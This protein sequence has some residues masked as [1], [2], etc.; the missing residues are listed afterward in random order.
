MCSVMTEKKE[1]QGGVV[2]MNEI[3]F[4]FLVRLLLRTARG[5]GVCRFS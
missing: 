5:Q 3:G 1:M 4:W 2:G